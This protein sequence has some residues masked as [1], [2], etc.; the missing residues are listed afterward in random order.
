MGKYLV[1]G[2]SSGIGKALVEQLA[3]NHEVYATYNTNEIIGDATAS[4]KWEASEDFDISWLPEELNGLIY[5]PGAINLKPFKRFSDDDFL[6]DYKVQF[7]GAVKV[8]RACLKLLK[9][10]EAVSSITLFSSVAATTG[11]N[12]HSVVSS[13]KGAVEG[14][15]RSLAA[16]FAPTIRVNAVALS[17]TNTPLAEK[18]LNT[19]EKI[20]ANGKRHPLGRI[21]TT[22]DAVQAVTYLLHNSWVTG[23]ILQVDGGFG[24]IK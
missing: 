19:E 10:K 3:Q 1:V 8:I 22:E 16:E 14:L 2:G 11:L 5:C 13:T 7:L 12:F 15:V 17:L 9:S 6:N 24:V 4:F 23:Q 18:L 21:G 20:E